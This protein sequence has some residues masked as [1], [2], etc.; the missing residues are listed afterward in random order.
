MH[1]CTT[2]QQVKTGEDKTGNK[3]DTGQKKKTFQSKT[4]TNQGNKRNPGLNRGRVPRKQ[5]VKVKP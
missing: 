3:I 4:G 1:R 2:Q 5:K